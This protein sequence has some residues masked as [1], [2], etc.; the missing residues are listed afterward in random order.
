MRLADN[1]DG[2]SKEA[3]TLLNNAIMPGK[4]LQKAVMICTQSIIQS[5]WSTL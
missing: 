3:S 2:P 1:V 5:Y 4:D